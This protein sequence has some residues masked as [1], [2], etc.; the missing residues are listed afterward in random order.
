MKPKHRPRPGT[1]LLAAGRA[2]S[3]LSR[4]RRGAICHSSGH[5]SRCSFADVD[6]LVRRSST[7]SRPG[8]QP[9]CPRGLRRGFRCGQRSVCEGRDNRLSADHRSGPAAPARRVWC[10][11]ADRRGPSGGVMAS[12]L[13]LPGAGPPRLAGSRPRRTI[14]ARACS[15]QFCPG[16]PLVPAGLCS[17]TPINYPVSLFTSIST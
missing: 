3:S 16:R 9:T 10:L 11:C 5:R 1:R 15:P 12:G 2:C 6:D 13:G 17:S 14:T 4:R 8:W 7:P